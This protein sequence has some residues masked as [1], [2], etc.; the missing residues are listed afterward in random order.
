MAAE[1]TVKKVEGKDAE[2]VV[3][4]PSQR[5]LR[6]F[7]SRLVRAAAARSADERS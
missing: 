3:V 2:K 6:S 4:Y 7:T 1:T 5:G